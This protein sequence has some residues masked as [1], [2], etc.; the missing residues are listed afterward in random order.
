MT[1]TLA[2]ERPNKFVYKMDSQSKAFPP[3]AAY[4]DG[5]TFINFKAK[6]ARVEGEA[7]TKEY[8]K[9][10]APETYKGI[11]IVDDVEFEP[12]ATYV[13]ALMLQG[14][15][16]AD[17]D[18]RAA[19]EQATVKPSVTENGKTW[20]VLEMPFGTGATRI[21]LYFG[22]DDHLIGKSLQKV[23]AGKDDLQKREI[24]ITETL[25]G[26]KVDKP[27]DA[28]TFQYTLPE[29]AKQVDR[30]S[31][32][33]RPNDALGRIGPSRRGAPVGWI[34]HVPFFELFSCP[35]T[36]REGRFLA[37]LSSSPPRSTVFSLIRAASRERGRPSSFF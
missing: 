24:K 9:A 12:I 21:T 18:V 29:D 13:I 3:V 8:T 28:A 15:A 36:W 17:K 32:P 31:A 2:L 35:R 26:I 1:F 27:I 7:A 30:F 20:Q 16:L 4:C 19:L 37:L 6:F 25:E 23:E 33:Q 5:T 34:I 14:D 11:N 10:S 22:K